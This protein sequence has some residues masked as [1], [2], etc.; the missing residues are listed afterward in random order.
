MFLLS[1]ACYLPATLLLFAAFLLYDSAT[2]AQPEK[3]TVSRG[4]GTLVI[5]QAIERFQTIKT[6]TSTVRLKCHFFGEGYGGQGFYHEKRMPAVQESA[7]TLPALS[8]N[9]FLLELK[10]QPDSLPSLENRSSTLKVIANGSYLWKFTDIENEILLER[11]N[12]AELQEILTKTQRGN[13]N[14]NPLP[15]RGLGELTSLGGLEGTLIKMAKFYDFDSASVESAHLDSENRAVWK[16]SAKLKPDKLKAMIESYGGEKSVAKH[17]G[18]HIPA[19]VSI[20]FGKE[21][22]FPYQIS[23]Y[24]GIKE[25]PFHDSPNIELEYRNPSINGADIA[26]TFFDYRPPTIFYEDVTEI[27]ANR[28]LE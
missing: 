24:G 28:L 8:P 26:T 19:A 17:G 25:N 7:A 12:L 23:Y 10:F 3:K 16:V 18:M 22:Y 4:N 21:N 20:Y 11:V 5:E 15:L 6:I 27:Y 14:I 2:S 9:R 13:G 1:V